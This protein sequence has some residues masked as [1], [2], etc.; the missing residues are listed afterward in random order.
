MT[1]QVYVD[2]SER[3]KV[4]NRIFDFDSPTPVIALLLVTLK[5]TAPTSAT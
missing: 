3:K 4:R 5:V 1:G 2:L